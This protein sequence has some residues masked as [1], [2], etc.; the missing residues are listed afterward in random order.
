MQPT[1]KARTG[2]TTCTGSLMCQGHLTGMK[3]VNAVKIVLRRFIKFVIQRF[4][5][6]KAKK[7]LEWISIY[8]SPAINIFTG[9]HRHS[10]TNRRFAQWNRKWVNAIV[11]ISRSQLFLVS[12]PSL[13]LL[14]SVEQQRSPGSRCPANLSG[15]EYATV[16]GSS[17]LRP[18]HHL[19]QREEIIFSFVSHIFHCV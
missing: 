19:Q 2:N 4:E 1:Q 11:L 9:V 5:E 15:R 8:C 16:A 12:C 7:C 13:D 3:M 18:C 10:Q 6:T 17:L 14:L